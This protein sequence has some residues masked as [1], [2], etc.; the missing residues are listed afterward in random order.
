MGLATTLKITKIA[1]K[2]VIAA[3]GRA[4]RMKRMCLV[5]KIAPTAALKTAGQCIVF[6]LN[7]APVLIGFTA[8]YK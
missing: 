7:A 1:Q 4:I 6:H 8:E 2:T 5:Q 3:M